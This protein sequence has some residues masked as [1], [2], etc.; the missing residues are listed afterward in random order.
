MLILIPSEL[1]KFTNIENEKQITLVG[2]GNKFEIWNTK[3]W[4]MRQTGGSL[5]TEIIDVVMPE[6]IK[7]MSF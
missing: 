4:E 3:D 6:S 5:S 7:A 2:M 1:R